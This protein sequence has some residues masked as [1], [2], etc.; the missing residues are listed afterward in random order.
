MNKE[1]KV[2]WII[3]TTDW[4]NKKMTHI[5]YGGFQEALD[6]MCKLWQEDK[7]KFVGT[8]ELKRRS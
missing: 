3:V 6:K 1:I 8:P 2:R 4:K 5:V 7:Y